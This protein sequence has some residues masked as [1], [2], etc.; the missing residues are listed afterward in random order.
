MDIP[1]LFMD[2]TWVQTGWGIRKPF[3]SARDEKGLAE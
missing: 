2:T 1:L 3:S